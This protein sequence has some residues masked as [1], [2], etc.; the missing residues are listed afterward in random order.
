MAQSL[1]DDGDSDG[2]EDISKIEID[3][4]FARRFEHNKKREDLQRLEE[5]RKRGEVSD[6]SEESSSEEEEEDEVAGSKKT[7]IQFYDAIVRVKRND[8][9]IYQKDA[10]LRRRRRGGR[11]NRKAKKEKPLYIK[12][13]VAKHLLEEGPEYE[14]DQPSGPVGRRSKS[15]LEELEENKRAF[16]EAA[17]ETVESDG[18]DL[19]LEKKT[20]REQTADEDEGEIQKKLDEFFGEDENLD[21]N[22]VFL[23]NFFLNKMWLDRDKAKEPVD[24][25]PLAVSEDED[26][27]EKQEKYEAE[28]NFRYQ[29]G[30]GDR[31]LGHSRVTEGTVRKKTNARKLQRKS[32]EERMSQAELE[33]KEELKRLKNLKKKEI[34]EKLEK[35]RKI[36]GI[37]EG[38]ECALDEDDLEEEFDPEEYD[39]KM[40]KVFD[41][42]YYDAEDADPGFDSG[43]DENLEKPDFDM[44]DEL[45]GLPKD[46][47]NSG[48]ADGFQ[49][50]RAKILNRKE[51]A[52]TEPQSEG[53]RKRKRKISLREKVELEKAMEEYYKLDY[54]GTIGDLKTRFKYKP[55]PSNRYGLSAEE[56]LLADD[57]EL[58]QYVSLKKIAPY[59]EEEWKVSRQKRYHQKMKKKLLL[60]GKESDSKKDKG[61]KSDGRG[62]ADSGKS[63]EP[64]DDKGKLSRRSKRRRRQGELKLSQS[65]L[66]AYG[67]I[68]PKSK[69]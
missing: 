33:R 49:A 57:K 10:K 36:A 41:V 6:S 48:S 53:K 1:F 69:K 54:E 19:F 61:R 63:S 4:D 24:E 18:E 34:Q 68:P 25:D 22:E 9:A 42:D 27:L 65:R 58:N 30:A 47:I 20:A 51:E 3:Q 15:Y 17:G 23:K 45:L 12:D 38:G 62:S 46:W 5:L 13:V 44:E 26:Q 29:E 66:M 56:I 14:D 2:A 11:G 60:L 39:R 7:D 35:I 40:K 21:E 67:K 16:L 32:K 8:P 50:A 64:G 31:V 37:A 52:E 28:F 59:R 43:G 55:V